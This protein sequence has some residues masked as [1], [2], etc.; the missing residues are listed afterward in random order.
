MIN[1]P[2]IFITCRVHKIYI[3]CFNENVC[4]G[5]KKIAVMSFLP[6]Y[7]FPYLSKTHMKYFL[8][9]LCIHFI[10][11]IKFWICQFFLNLFLCESKLELNIRKRHYQCK[12]TPFGSFKFCASLRFG[13]LHFCLF[14]IVQMID[15]LSLVNI[16]FICKVDKLQQI[17]LILKLIE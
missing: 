11:I 1:F 15:F 3:R 2:A 17:I 10:F 9:M 8:Q 14:S 6:W 16:T 5:K 7:H 12:N 13:S 4:C